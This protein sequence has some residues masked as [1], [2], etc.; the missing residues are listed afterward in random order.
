MKPEQVKKLL[1]SKIRY[2]ADHPETYSLNP[3]SDF[4]RKRKIPLERLLTGVIGLG[5]GSLSNELL[6]MFHRSANTASSSA[7]V[8]Q[9]NKLK[10]DAFEDIFRAFS[11]D[12]SAGFHEDMK[13]LA[14]DG[15][16]IHIFTDPN[17]TGSYYQ[18]A[19]G[20]QPY[21]LLHLN[22]LYDLTHHI[23]HDAV[24]QKRNEEN[25]HRALCSM[26]DRSAIPHALVIADRG[27]ESYNDMAHIQEKGWNFLIRIKEGKNSIK[28]N[29][30]L[31]DEPVF[32][33][34]IRLNITRKQSNET[35]ELCK[36]K[37]HYRYLPTNAT[38]DY[39]PSKSSYT[40]PAAFYELRFRVV[41]FPISEDA[42][43][44]ILT[45]LDREHYP[46]DTLKHLYSLRWG[47]ETPFRDLKYTIGL[48]K[49]HSKKVMCILQEIF[50]Q[51][52]MYNFAEMITSNVFIEKKHRKYTYKAN[53]S[54]AAH[55]CR[56]FYLG[57][58]TSPDLEAII[59]R[60]LIPIRPERHRQRNPSPKAFQGF[61]YRI[62]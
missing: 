2:V 45:N 23:Y 3:G 56:A 13:I 25:E 27:Y 30:E 12:I 51:L 52:T 42:Y 31:P 37:N 43:E 58:T 55:M 39:L 10:P 40:T 1:Y 14:V 11:D 8:Q 35:K 49:L 48:L 7:F 53:F 5:G 61:L 36:D 26:V 19:N 9:R 41:R 59:A 33:L 16:D 24:I 47:I 28:G 46:P 29:L 20:Q 62:A 38:F 17:D 57:K 15:S 50:A 21:N 4:T 18:G 32:D 6:D 34:E 44:T 60:N 22:A 54:V